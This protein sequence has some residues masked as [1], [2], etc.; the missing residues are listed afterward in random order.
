MIPKELQ[1]LRN[2]LDIVDKGIVEKIA[3]RFLITQKIWQVKKE[4][5]LPKCDPDR[6]KEK[7]EEVSELAKKYQLSP[8]IAGKIFEKI[9]DETK[10][11]YLD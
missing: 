8:K 4:N 10:N 1:L 6:E 5:D 2:S 7:L 3:E 9:I 11:S